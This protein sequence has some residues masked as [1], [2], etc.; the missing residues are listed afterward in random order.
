MSKKNKKSK[1]LKF[2]KKIKSLQIELE[3]LRSEIRKLKLS[4]GP[5]RQSKKAKILARE[6]T[7][8]MATPIPAKAGT[9]P[10]VSGE[11]ESIAARVVGRS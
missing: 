1:F 8:K 7:P 6:P 3:E 4:S 5:R 11:E 2:E 9:S 10:A